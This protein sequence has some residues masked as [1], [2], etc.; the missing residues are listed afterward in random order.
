MITTEEMKIIFEHSS[1]ILELIECHDEM[2]QSDLQGVSEAIVLNIIRST[3][4]LQ[5]GN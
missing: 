4:E 3:K 1:K 2:T 5:K